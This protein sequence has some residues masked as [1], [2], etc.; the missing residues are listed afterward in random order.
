MSSEQI[1]VRRRRLIPIAPYTSE[2]VEFAATVDKPQDVPIEEAIKTL[3][4]TLNSILEREFP[5]P[6]QDETDEYSA[7]PWRQSKRCPELSTLLVNETL[8][9]KARELYG[10]LKA[11]KTLRTQYYEYRLSITEDGREFLQRWKLHR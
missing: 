3:N 10:T 4:G 9:E 7:L 5:F 1:T 11:A 6:H 2:E 8:P